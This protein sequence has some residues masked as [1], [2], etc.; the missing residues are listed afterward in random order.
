MSLR[1]VVLAVVLVFL[2]GCVG[3]LALIAAGSNRHND[4]L[5]RELECLQQQIKQLEQE[6][7][8]LEQENLQL[9]ENLSRLI[10]QFSKTVLA[11]NV[12]EAVS[13]DPRLEIL[14]CNVVWD[15]VTLGANVVVKVRNVGNAPLK[16]AYVFLIVDD[17]SMK[18]VGGYM[19]YKVLHDLWMGEEATVSFSFYLQPPPPFKVVAVAPP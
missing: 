2:V 13:A 1:N 14:S 18:I 4:G 3:V 8:R 9:K 7:Q 6:R 10:E 19:Y 17:G 15:N 11:V 16:T 12:S 5:Q